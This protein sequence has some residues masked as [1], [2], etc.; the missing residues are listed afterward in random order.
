MEEELRARLVAAVETLV[1]AGQIVWSQRVG[2]V[3]PAIVLHRITGRPDYTMRGPSGLMDSIV[4]IDCW[5]SSAMSVLTVSRAVK[6]ALSAWG[7]GL[8]S[9]V[10]VENERSSFEQ[11][12]GAN[13]AVEPSEFHRVSLDFR[14]WHH[15]AN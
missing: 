11:A 9:R 3:L 7:G 5:G 4:Q 13:G 14:V 15:D 10:F 6:A 2:P 1:P 12:E 8:I